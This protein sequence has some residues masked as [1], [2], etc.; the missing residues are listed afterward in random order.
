MGHFMGHDLVHESLTIL[1]QQGPVEAQPAALV[2]R[3]PGT[4]TAQI[5]PHLRPR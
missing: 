4:T 3:L 5:E 1:S 2:M